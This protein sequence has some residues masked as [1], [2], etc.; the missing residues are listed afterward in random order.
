[1]LVRECPLVLGQ[2]R[3]LNTLTLTAL[4]NLLPSQLNTMVILCS[5]TTKRSWTKRRAHS[6]SQ[7]LRLSKLIALLTRSITTISRLYAYRLSKQ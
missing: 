6:A 1:M 5:L 2:G 7:R 4:R 3:V